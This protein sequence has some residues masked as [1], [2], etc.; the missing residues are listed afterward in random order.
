M[1]LPLHFALALDLNPGSKDSCDSLRR[2]KFVKCIIITEQGRTEWRDSDPATTAAPSGDRHLPAAAR[3]RWRE[4]RRPWETGKG[5]GPTPHRGIRRRARPGC[6]AT[7]PLPPGQRQA[8]AE[9]HGKRGPAGP[10]AKAACGRP[11]LAAHSTETVPMWRACSLRATERAVSRG[12]R[13]GLSTGLP[14]RPI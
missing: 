11:P 4:K 3:C 6:L 10:R 2:T 13:R 8:L 7:P 1:R 14:R 12:I 5:N 9:V